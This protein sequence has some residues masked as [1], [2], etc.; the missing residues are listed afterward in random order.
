MAQPLVF[1]STLQASLKPYL[2]TP[3]DTRPHVTLTYASSLDAQISLAPGT[4]TVL[5]G[6]MSKAMTHYL[7]FE[8]DGILIGANTAIADDPGLGCRL[9]SE[10]AGEVAGY[11]SQPRPVIVD[12]RGRWQPKGG[13]VVRTAADGVGKAPWWFV[14]CELSTLPQEHIDAVLSVGGKVVSLGGERIQWEELMGRLKKEGLD[15]VM[16][17][18]GA[19]VIG[20]LLGQARHLVGSVIITFA[21]V[22]LGRGGVEVIPDRNGDGK[23]E[24]G[25]L[26][27][28]KWLPMEED[29]VLAGKLD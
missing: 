10:E 24:V 16:V 1:P 3:S 15:S 12:G 17:E 9:Y 5:S 14:C 11:D 22:W 23:G 6:L 27:D 13:R 4:Q 26:R 25:R 8:H 19:G 18:G 28:V 2:P 29:V 20:Q 21:P 7:R